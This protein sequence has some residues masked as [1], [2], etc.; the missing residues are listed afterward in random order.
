M[1]FEIFWL[2]PMHGFFLITNLPINFHRI[3][4]FVSAKHII[5]L[6]ESQ[7]IHLAA[8]PLIQYCH[9]PLS[10]PML[11]IGPVINCCQVTEA[12][13]RVKWRHDASPVLERDYFPSPRDIITFHV[14]L[15]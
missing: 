13:T 12:A 8:E 1:I 2:Q 9:P 15:V 14:E 5:A 7:K 3:K 6:K 10:K 11:T 4:Y